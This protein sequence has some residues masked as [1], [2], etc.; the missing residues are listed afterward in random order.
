MNSKVKIVISIVCLM[1]LVG[2]II[3]VSLIG[4]NGGIF[5]GSAFLIGI[6]AMSLLVLWADRK[7]AKQRKTIY[8]LEEGTAAVV[9]ATYS[10]SLLFNSR[11]KKTSSKRDNN[12]ETIY[13]DLERRGDLQEVAVPNWLPDDFKKHW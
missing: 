1:V 6:A 8:G 4:S 9:S 2:W 13:P 7:R 10:E 11:D 12:R 5:I 3:G